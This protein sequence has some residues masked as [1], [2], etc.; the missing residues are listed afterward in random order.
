MHVVVSFEKWCLESIELAEFY[1]EPVHSGHFW[2]RQADMI[3]IFGTKAFFVC[4]ITTH[5]S[6]EG[7]NPKNTW[8]VLQGRKFRRKIFLHKIIVPYV[9]W[10][11]LLRWFRIW[12]WFS[13]KLSS[14]WKNRILPRK[15]GF[16]GKPIAQCWNIRA[17]VKSVLWMEEY[18]VKVSSNLKLWKLIVLNTCFWKTLS[19]KEKLLFPNTK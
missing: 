12:P 3:Y 16:F 6:N 13:I 8:G 15:L 17:N 9:F 11:S 5:T 2:L 14:N 19:V 10:D 18:S 7:W 4:I 1:S